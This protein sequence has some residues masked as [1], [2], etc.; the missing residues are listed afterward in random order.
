MSDLLTERFD[1]YFRHPNYAHEVLRSGDRAIACENLRAGADSA[2]VARAVYA[3]FERKWTPRCPG[4]VRSLQE[5][6]EELF[7]FLQFPKSQ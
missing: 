7:T 2:P 5:G 1:R 6:G 3:A 4:V